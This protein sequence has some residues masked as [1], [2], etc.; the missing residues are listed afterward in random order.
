MTSYNDMAQILPS[1]WAL[2]GLLVGRYGELALTH[3]AGQ[4]TAAD[5]SG[6]TESAHIWRDVIT[7]L[8]VTPR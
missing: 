3:A 1:C 8:R 7:Y 6:D 5:R 4:A 2:A